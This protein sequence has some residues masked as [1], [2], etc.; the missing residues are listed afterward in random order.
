MLGSFISISI[1]PFHHSYPFHPL[2]YPVFKKAS[3][4]PFVPPLLFLA[5]IPFNV[6]PAERTVYVIWL[7]ESAF[8]ADH[9]T[10]PSFALS[11]SKVT[12]NLRRYHWEDLETSW[13]VGNKE[14]RSAGPQGHTYSRTHHRPGILAAPWNRVSASIGSIRSCVLRS[15]SSS[16]PK[17]G[18]N[19]AP[20]ANFPGTQ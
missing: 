5:S 17:I 2:L 9:E 7:V 14:P 4:Y 10:A 18:E 12:M 16:A 13:F 19:L 11:S 8:R 1:Y 3:S 20:F 15:Y 6:Y